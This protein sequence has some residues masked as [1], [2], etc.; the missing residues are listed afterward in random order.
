MATKGTVLYIPHGGGPLPLMD[1]PGHARLNAFLTAVPQALPKPDAV[2]VISAHWEMDIPVVT[3]HE[4]PGLIYDYYGF[5][6]ETYEISYPASGQPAL[7]EKSVDLLTAAGIKARLDS[8]RGFDHGLFIPLAR[9]LPKA[10]IP[11]IQISLCAD[12]DPL[13]HLNLGEALRPLTRENI[14]ILGSGFSFHNMGA[15]GRGASSTQSQGSDSDQDPDQDNQDFQDWL[16]QTCTGEAAGQKDRLIRWE[17]APGAR[18]CHPKEEHLLPL[19]VCAGAAGY[20]PAEKVF[21]D[22]IMDRRA[23]AFLWRGEAG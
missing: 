17:T 4:R 13:S 12:L 7:A 18:H 10:D 1:D 2:V 8:G 20:R 5:P 22:R 11:C 15:F 3:A 23:L 21:D 16:D 9:M 14:L 6:R 19:M